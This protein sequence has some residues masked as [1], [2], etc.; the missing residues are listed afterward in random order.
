[1]Y[2]LYIQF[3]LFS[4]HL[5]FFVNH[6]LIVLEVIIFFTNKSCLII[7]WASLVAQLVKNLPAMQET[8][9]RSLGWEDPLEEE[10]A[11][12]S[13]ILAWEIP[14]TVKPGGLQSMGSQ[15]RTWLSD[16]TT[17]TNNSLS[18]QTDIYHLVIKALRYIYWVPTVYK[19]LSLNAYGI[20]LVS[21][22]LSSYDKS[23]AS[24]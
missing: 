24:P 22:C 5:I 10:M 19:A 14:W 18:W 9:V 4:F 6:N 11:T 13:S 16:W 21:H 15:S 7:R 12:H 8:P 20:A 3:F 23:I 17:A 2:I 1:M